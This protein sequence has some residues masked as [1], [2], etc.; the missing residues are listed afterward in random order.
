MTRTSFAAWPCPIARAIDLLGD[1]W[2]LLILRDAFFFGTTRFADFQDGLGIPSNVLSN[3]LATLVEHGVL[4]KHSAP[5]GR[6]LH[7]YRPTSKGSE[8]WTVLAAMLTWGNRWL[9]D[10]ALEELPLQHKACGARVTSDRCSRC[11]V[12]LG[13]EEIGIEP[14]A[15]VKVGL[16]RLSLYGRDSFTSERDVDRALVT[17]RKMARL[18][19]LDAPSLLVELERRGMSKAGLERLA[20][21]LDV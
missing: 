14:A 9:T 11:G 3:R 21:L 12:R 2:T 20:P 18:G 7:E 5:V 16:D 13:L 8:L 17:I 10:A 1:G 6:S 19:C 4:A 15:F